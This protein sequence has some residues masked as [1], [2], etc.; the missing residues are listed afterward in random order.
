MEAKEFVTAVITAMTDG[1]RPYVDAAISVASSDPCIRQIIVCVSED[2]HWIGNPEG[3]ELLLLPL[4]PVGAVRNRAVERAR[5]PWVAFCDGDDFWLPDKTSVQLRA[6]ES[7]ASFIGACHYLIDEDGVTRANG[8]AKII[9]M[10]SSWLIR[11]SLMLEIPFNESIT[12]GDDVEWWG[13]AKHCHRARCPERLIKYRVREV[14]LSRATF[15][16]KRKLFFVKLA[17]KPLLGLPI[18]F[19]TWLRWLSLWG[20]RS[21]S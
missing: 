1:E 8:F 3:V 10:P 13:R 19:L 5:Y 9:P 17:Q 16:K 15:T 12:Q 18:Y 21:Y 6:A 7:G 11:R 14:S 20:K 4:M 2:N